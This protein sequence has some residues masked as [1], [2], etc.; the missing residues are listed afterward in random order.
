MNICLDYGHVYIGN[1]FDSRRPAALF[2]VSPC[3]AKLPAGCRSVTACRFEQA[4]AVVKVLLEM[5]RSRQ[6]SVAVVGSSSRAW[7]QR[8]KDVS[9]GVTALT[10]DDLDD[11]RLRPLTAHYHQQLVHA[12]DT[13]RPRG[14][15]DH[16]SCHITRVFRGAPVAE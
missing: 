7:D 14:A 9:G 4:K 6:N 13:L 10:F 1:F 8:G 5:L 12:V 11:A 3:S 2:W 16:R 15:S